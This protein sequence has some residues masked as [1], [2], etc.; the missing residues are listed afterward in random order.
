MKWRKLYQ[1]NIKDKYKVWDKC[2]NPY[3]PKDEA[4]RLEITSDR[5][6][7]IFSKRG[8]SFEVTPETCRSGQV[9]PCMLEK[10]GDVL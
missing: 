5:I 2:P 1:L 10:I 3:I 6:E 8:V 7:I 4:G 9:H